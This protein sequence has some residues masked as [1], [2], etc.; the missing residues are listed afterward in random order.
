MKNMPRMS[1]EKAHK[2]LVDLLGY[3]WNTKCAIQECGDHLFFIDSDEDD[4]VEGIDWMPESEYKAPEAPKESEEDRLERERIEAKHRESLALEAELKQCKRQI[5]D[6]WH[7]HE[8]TLSTI[9]REQQETQRAFDKLRQ[10]TS[11]SSLDV[12]VAHL[13]RNPG[14][15]Y[16]DFSGKEESLIFQ[17]MDAWIVRWNDQG[18]L[19]VLAPVRKEPAKKEPKRDP[20]ES[21]KHALKNGEFR[22]KE[23]AAERV[24]AST[25]HK[26]A[27][28]VKEITFETAIGYVER[29]IT[30]GLAEER[31]NGRIQGRG[32]SASGE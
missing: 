6:A 28:G 13:A 23:D 4:V 10:R 12:A 30:E 20:F 32:W 8:N 29:A 26:E 16:A 1:R 14:F 19:D 7:E 22:S 15:S 18:G 31:Y 24:Q 25:R 2:W 5:D 11:Y 17:A 27:W 9:K 3:E 21:V